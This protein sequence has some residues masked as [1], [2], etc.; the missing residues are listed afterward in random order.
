[1]CLD[2]YRKLEGGMLTEKVAKKPEDW[3]REKD[4]EM[5]L[6]GHVGASG[7]YLCELLAEYAKS[8]RRVVAAWVYQD[9]AKRVREFRPVRMN[10]ENTLAIAASGLERLSEE[11]NKP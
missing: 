5:L 6:S 11:A 9:A 7:K 8:E 4:L 10:P 3:L 1:M 2:M